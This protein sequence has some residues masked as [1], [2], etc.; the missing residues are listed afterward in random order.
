MLSE[1]LQKL[2]HDR[3]RKIMI[4]YKITSNAQW[5]KGTCDS[6]NNVSTDTHESREHAQA[7]CDRLEEKG[8]GGDG[9]IFPIKTWVNES[10]PCAGR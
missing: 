5:P 9:L 1:S 8:F 4:P 7:V 6:R 2:T 10:D 3:C